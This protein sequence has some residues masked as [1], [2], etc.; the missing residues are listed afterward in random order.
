MTET[1]KII[2]PADTV[3]EVQINGNKM[4][5][6]NTNVSVNEFIAYLLKYAASGDDVGVV[7]ENE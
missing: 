3:K 7:V 4:C 6:I 2:V 5:E 1:F